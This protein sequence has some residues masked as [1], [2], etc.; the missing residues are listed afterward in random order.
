[1]PETISFGQARSFS[2]NRI[3]LKVHSGFPADTFQIIA[4]YDCGNRPT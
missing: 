1:M 3:E 4:R 2:E